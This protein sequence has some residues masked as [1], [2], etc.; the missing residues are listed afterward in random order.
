MLR[1][2]EVLLV[3]EEKSL[4]VLTYN[5]TKYY[6]IYKMWDDEMGRTCS[7]QWTNEVVI[8]KYVRRR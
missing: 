8:Q 2:I 7:K 1:E 6:Q 5:F 4:I 3:Y